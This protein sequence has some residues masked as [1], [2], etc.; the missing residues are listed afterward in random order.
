MAEVALL[1]ERG[2][3]GADDDAERGHEAGQHEEVARPDVAVERGGSARDEGGEKKVCERKS[4]AAKRSPYV[5]TIPAATAS[6]TEALAITRC[7]ERRC[8]RR[9][10][11]S[12][13]RLMMKKQVPMSAASEVASTN[14]GGWLIPRSHASAVMTRMSMVEVAAVV[15]R[16][17][18]KGNSQG[19]MRKAAVRISIR[20]WSAARR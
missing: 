12:R 5:V 2:A 16:L 15:R 4:V 6:T 13:W 10:T 9:R 7:S 8:S 3:E 14:K 17:N 19:R 18:R 20:C 11:S 1:F